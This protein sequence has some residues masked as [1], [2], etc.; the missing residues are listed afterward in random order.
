[1]RDFADA[2]S[3]RL[4][5]NVEP[6][7]RQ[8]CRDQLTELAAFRREARSAAARPRRT[9]GTAQEL[10]ATEVVRPRLPD[11]PFPVDAAARQQ[12]LTVAT[13][14]SARLVGKLRPTLQT[15]PKILEIRAFAAAQPQQHASHCRAS[16]L[17]DLT[18]RHPKLGLMGAATSASL[19]PHGERRGKAAGSRQG[20]RLY[21]R[22]MELDLKRLLL[23]QNLPRLYRTVRE[24]ATK[25]RADGLAAAIA[26]CERAKRLNVADEWLRPTLLAAAFD[27][28]D[29]DRP[30][31]WPMM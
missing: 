16:K 31:N 10:I 11:G 27:L 26:A 12:S 25:A 13:G 22:G 2:P 21:E 4:S 14:T 30:K 15:N 18:D 28:A 1:V 3:I 23:L 7:K 6:R 20:D 17:I 29:P 24:P 19:K 9:H 5:T 8:R